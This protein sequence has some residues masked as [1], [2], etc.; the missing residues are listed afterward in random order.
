MYLIGGIQYVPC[1]LMLCIVRVQLN[2]VDENFNSPNISKLTFVLFFFTLIYIYC[3]ITGYIV[4]VR[5]C[6][7]IFQVRDKICLFLF[8][9]QW[10]TVCLYSSVDRYPFNA[11]HTTV[12]WLSISKLQN[13]IFFFFFLPPLL[14]KKNIKI[15]GFILQYWTLEKKKE[16]SSI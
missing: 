15:K 9:Q 8:I 7:K 6:R 1:C 12:V 11:H 2:I 16:D 10:M 4:A 3:V 5:H 13:N 14:L